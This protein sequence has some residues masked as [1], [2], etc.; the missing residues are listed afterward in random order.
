MDLCE[1]NLDSIRFTSLDEWQVMRYH[2]HIVAVIS[3]RPEHKETAY[4][5]P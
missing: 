1:I 5:V 3:N 4:G 2:R